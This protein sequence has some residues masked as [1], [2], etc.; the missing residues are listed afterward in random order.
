MWLFLVQWVQCAVRF[1]QMVYI[2]VKQMQDDGHR[3]L[4]SVVINDF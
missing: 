1:Q 4:E 3:L 2:V